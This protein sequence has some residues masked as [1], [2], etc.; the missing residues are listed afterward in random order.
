MRA[1]RTLVC[2]K[3]I[4]GIALITACGAAPNDETSATT[5]VS[6][7]DEDSGSPDGS[8]PEPP[9]CTVLEDG[10][11]SGGDK[12]RCC[13][14]E[15][16]RF[17]FEARCW[18]PAGPSRSAAHAAVGNGTLTCV[19]IAEGSGGCREYGATVCIARVLPDGELE[20]IRT[21]N[22]WVGEGWLTCEDP[23]FADFKLND[24]PRN[25]SGRNV[26]P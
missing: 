5:T 25:D 1:F 22:V 16:A 8:N 20:V 9:A 23:V 14:V 21:S 3:A 15:G 19:P 4:A 24:L 10:T 18:R 6:S 13:S 11:C 26:C 12:T 17:D 7:S 2:L